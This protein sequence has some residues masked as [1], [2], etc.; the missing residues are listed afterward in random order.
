MVVLQELLITHYVKDGLNRGLS[1][2]RVVLQESTCPFWKL[3]IDPHI[4]RLG[5]NS[6]DAASFFLSVIPKTVGDLRV[7]KLK[8]PLWEFKKG[9]KINWNTGK[10]R[11]DQSH[12]GRIG[13][14]FPSPTC[15]PFQN[16]IN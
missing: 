9:E 12:P 10:A 8:R 2:L 3:Q 6:L 7:N 13:K 16:F 4:Y 5:P 15:N 14:E 11:P 1:A